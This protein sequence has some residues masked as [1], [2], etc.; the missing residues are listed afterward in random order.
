MNDQYP[1]AASVAP[2]RAASFAWATDMR[3][4]RTCAMVVDIALVAGV[5]GIVSIVSAV[6]AMVTFGLSSFV[7][8]MAPF[9][10]AVTHL[11]NAGYLQGKSGQSIGKKAFGLKV[12]TETE[13]T[14][15]IGHFIGR[16]ALDVLS[17]VACFTVVDRLIALFTPAQRRPIDQMLKLNV[18][19]VEAHP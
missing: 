8:A 16:A 10:G 17:L 18:I 15:T 3:T 12:V 9:L 7:N 14:P 5:Y 13:G 4:A 11:A 1:P 6:A 19:P 2:A